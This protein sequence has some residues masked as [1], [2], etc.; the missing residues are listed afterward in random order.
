MQPGASSD[1]RDRRWTSLYDLNLLA[2]M[3]EQYAVREMGVLRKK[4]EA[5]FQQDGEGDW[6]Y[7]EYIPAVSLW[8][9]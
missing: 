2:G 6:F 4:W 5:K 9:C 8:R 3:Q 7:V 1:P